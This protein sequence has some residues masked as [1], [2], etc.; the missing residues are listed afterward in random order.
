MPAFRLFRVSLILAL[1]TPICGCM[2]GP[3]FKHP[4]APAIQGYTAKPL[5]HHTVSI[6]GPGGKA[7]T[8]VLDQDLPA[9]WWTLFHNKA[10]TAMVERGIQQS[11]NMAAAQAALANAKETL[12]AQI[13]NSLFPAI[14]ANIGGERQG[15]DVTPGSGGS[16]S[17]IFN[18]FNAN[19]N[20]AYTL[21]LFGSSR[22]EIEA[23]AAQVDYQQFQ[24]LATY[25]SLTSNMVITSLNLASTTAQ[26]KATHELIKVAQETLRLMKQQYALGAIAFTNMLTQETL[27]AQTE[28]TLPPLQQAAIQYEHALA[29]LMGGYPDTDIA[30]LVLDKIVLPKN[31]PVSL[32]AHLVQQRPDVRASEALLH[33]ANAQ[34]GV[35][36][37]NLFPQFTLT[38]SGGWS[39]NIASQLFTP[40][41]KV[42][43][44]AGSITQPI[45]QGGALLATR[46]AAIAA[47]QQAG[48]QYQ[49]TVLQAFQNVADT[50][51]ALANDARTY[52]AQKAAEVAA[53][54]ALKI[55]REQYQLGGVN[56][57]NLLTAEQ[58]YQQTRLA[59]IQAQASRYIDTATLYQALGGGWWNRQASL[60]DAANRSNA[61]L[62]CP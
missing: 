5:P 51:R 33:A 26:I 20:V 60:C 4:D 53:F 6:K 57:L 3:D 21:D 7:Q 43:N 25:L 17:S 45:F 41:T 32:P 24:L 61:S 62:T 46:R 50:L 52:Q 49:Q 22:R 29:V 10:I 47:Y 27:V 30:H 34:V 48:A 23:L 18:T 58:N 19:L 15:T 14:S 39:A 56:Y 42:W 59:S 13:G 36:T 2:L 8:Y 54:K 44:Y 37:A 40:A 38:A 55:T 1:A 9:D 35:A 31:L 12:N 11:P 28:A 16:S